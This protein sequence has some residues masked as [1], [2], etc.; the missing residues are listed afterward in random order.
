MLQTC[1]TASWPNSLEPEPG[2]PVPTQPS[3]LLADDLAPADTALLDPELITA[4]A[5][6]LGGPTSH[7]TI[8]A[9]EL[10]I[11]CVVAVSG[12]EEVPSD[13]CVLVDGSSGIVHLDPDPQE[14]AERQRTAAQHA[15]EIARWQGQGRTSDGVGIELL[16]NVQDG[17]GARTAAQGVA[18][19]IGLFRTE[20]TFLASHTEPSIE[21]QAA[22]YKEVLEA[23]AGQKVVVRTLDAGS[24]K[25]LAFIPNQGEENPALGMRG[26]RV[27]RQAPEILERQLDAI[28]EAAGAASAH[29]MAPMVATPCEARGFA[30]K[31]RTRGL[32]PGVMIE[33]PAAALRARDVLE[34][35][36]FV[37]IGTNDLAQYTMAADRLSPTLSSLCDPWQ[38]AM[39]ELVRIVCEAG[40]ATGKPVG[41]CGESAADPLLATVL[42]GLGVTSLSAASTA[43][44]AVGAALGKVDLDTCQKAAAAA[45]DAFD[46]TQARARVREVTGL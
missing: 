12:L 13:Q 2:V 39:L 23:F 46:A 36:D 17:A 27:V 18:V 42:V 22:A 40:S 9:R 3:V 33:I 29:V 14:A 16:A 10:G 24:D 20:L 26:I 38:P 11:P 19:G 8:I 45:L 7:T 35:V 28:V 1:V 31:C 41:V 32:I 5:I 4:I 15:A 30:E 34:E 43:L 21:E 25:P 37:S 6:R 44:P